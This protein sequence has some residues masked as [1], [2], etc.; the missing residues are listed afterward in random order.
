M[1][2]PLSP[3]VPIRIGAV[4]DAGVMPHEKGFNEPDDPD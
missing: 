3:F 4:Y 1:P 2:I